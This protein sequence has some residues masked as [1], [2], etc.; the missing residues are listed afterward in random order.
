V[1]EPQPYFYALC[2]VYVLTGAA[3]ALAA[4]SRAPLGDLVLLAL[5]WPLYGPFLLTSGAPTARERDLARALRQV[6]GTPL[7]RLLP[8]RGSVQ[9]L[10]RALREAALRVREID[11]VLARP[12]MGEEA[13]L[14]QLRALEEAFGSPETR[15]ALAL[16]LQSIR[17][18]RELR[19]RFARRLTEVDALLAQLLAQVEVLR[20]GAGEPARDDLVAPL[21]AQVEAL[22]EMLEDGRRSAAVAAP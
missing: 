12:E 14:A 17:Q 20:L 15:A 3:C 5:L 18:L 10:E 7:G 2:T 9:A 1:S 6:A 21:L 16:R 13:T 22:A 4:R 11:A 19:E 8:D